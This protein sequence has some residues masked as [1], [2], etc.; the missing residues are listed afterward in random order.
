MNPL[1]LRMWASFAGAAAAARQ[2]ILPVA[3]PP[4]GAV[5]AA[6][7]SQWKSFPVA[8]SAAGRA[9]AERSQGWGP[10]PG[11]SRTAAS[12]TPRVWRCCQPRGE[13]LDKYSPRGGGRRQGLSTSTAFGVSP[14]VGTET[15][16]AP[17]SACVVPP[18]S[19]ATAGPGR[20]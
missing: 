15:P 5:A 7:A 14:Q 20:L 17:A 4:L 3:V 13:R 8:A 10:L 16:L 1:L 18:G 6:L 12:T 2:G 11:G 19:A 9:A